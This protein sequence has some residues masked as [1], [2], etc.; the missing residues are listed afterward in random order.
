MCFCVFKYWH[1]ICY[2]FFNFFVAFLF[3]T[4]S[5]AGAV[6]SEAAAAAA[7]AATAAAESALQYL[8]GAGIRNR[9]SATADRCATNE[10]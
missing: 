5:S 7:A 8:H 3:F 10:H 4:A 6:E 2:C 1:T 9:D